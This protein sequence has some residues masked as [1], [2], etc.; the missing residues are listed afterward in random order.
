MRNDSD[1][2]PESVATRLAI[3][4]GRGDEAVAVG[5]RAGIVEWTNSAWRRITGW[6]LEDVVGKPVAHML[7]SVGLE[8]DVLEFIQSRF[9]AG[10]RAAVEVPVE[11]PDGRL[12]HI[13]L[14]V[15]PIADESGDIAHFVAVATDASARRRAEISLENRRRREVTSDAYGEGSSDTRVAVAEAFAARSIEALRSVQRLCLEIER[16]TAI[17]LLDEFGV[18]S[19]RERATSAVDATLAL[20]EQANAGSTAAGPVDLG[21]LVE[22]SLCRV[23]RRVPDRVQLDVELD[24]ALP[25][26]RADECELADAI[27]RLMTAGLRAVDENWDTLSVTTGITKPGQPLVSPVHF[28]TFAGPLRDDR[29]RCFVEIHDTGATIPPDQLSRLRGSLFPIPRAERLAEL[30]EIRARLRGC[31]V[32][33]DV[34]STPGCGTRILLLVPIFGGSNERA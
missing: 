17:G 29:P 31:G 24:P 3:H 10:L 16:T 23:R 21:E 13:H 33:V 20:I 18:R 9:I 27:E 2:I 15:E 1:E 12:V 7:D 4:V 30:L 5:D 19:V 25:R 34:S 11:S 6:P 26:V 22:R 14:E 32:E 8:P 28:Q